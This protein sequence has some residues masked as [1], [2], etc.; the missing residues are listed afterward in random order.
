MCTHESCHPPTSSSANRAASFARTRAPTLVAPLARAVAPHAYI[1]ASPPFLALAVIARLL[2]PKGRRCLG[3]R[4]G[5]AGKHHLPA[6]RARDVDRSQDASAPHSTLR[7]ET[8]KVRRMGQ[9]L[10]SCLVRT[11]CP[12]AA[13]GATPRSSLVK[14]AL[15]KKDDDVAVAEL[16]HQHHHHNQ[17]QQ[18][19]QHHSP[20]AGDT[21]GGGEEDTQPLV[22][23]DESW[24]KWS[25]F[26]LIHNQSA[27]QKQQS[28]YVPPPFV[29]PRS[30]QQQEQQQHV[31][32]AEAVWDL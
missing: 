26:N 31:T 30:Q 18:Q 13:A 16:L 32:P 29:S 22:V 24:K 21:G 15:Q 6:S 12:S 20:E 9:R 23:E 2:D 8:E 14:P 27:L 17:Q 28:A 5:S 3:H 1:S 11:C 19:H 4:S 10:C 7:A 25:S